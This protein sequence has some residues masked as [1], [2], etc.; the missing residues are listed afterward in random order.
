MGGLPG[1]GFVIRIGA[2]ALIIFTFAVSAA[3]ADQGT[4]QPIRLAGTGFD[5]Y[6]SNPSQASQSWLRS[7][8]WRMIVY[9]PYFDSR[10]NWYPNGWVYKDAYAV[11]PSGSIP[12]EHPEWIFKGPSGEKLWIP[13]QCAKGTCPEYAGNITN[14]GFRQHWIE[15]AKATLAKG[16]KGLFIDD[17]NMEFN[18]SNGNG[19]HVSP[20][21]PATGQPM[22]STAW[23][24]YMAQFLEQI[25]SALP[26]IEII[27]NVVWFSDGP[28][29]LA[30][31]YIQREVKAANGVYLERGAD[32]A[33]LTGGNGPWSLEAF[34]SFEEGVNALGSYVVEGDAA[35][36]Q[37]EQQYDLASYFLINDG[38]DAIDV[39]FSTPKQFWPGWK[40]ELG[41]ARESRRVWEGLMRRDFT[42]GIDLLNEPGAPTRTVRLP[43]RMENTQGEIVSSVTL[44]AAS[45]AVLR[46]RKTAGKTLPGG[47]SAGPLAEPAPVSEQGIT[48]NLPDTAPAPVSELPASVAPSPPP[49]TTP[50]KPIVSTHRST[51]KR[52]LRQRRRKAAKRK[53]ARRSAA[54]H[55]TTKQPERPATK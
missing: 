30:D 37:Q 25:R 16:Y 53:T 13:Y 51:A 40:V 7:N 14:A 22:T 20:V 42:G 39:G 2:A 6:I 3:T 10:T 24:Q 50:K 8:L 45:G 33:G 27:H 5:E 36:N 4:V 43:K 47:G 44:P 38:S 11:Y 29:R 31:P 26:K 54:V 55:H 52:R 19:E 28:S 34:L 32:D 23:R 48:L 1:R 17:V 35:N 41:E 46:Y 18:V 15:E 12:S 21:D 9:S 49:S